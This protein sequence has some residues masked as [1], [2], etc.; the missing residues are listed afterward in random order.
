[1]AGTVLLLVIVAEPPCPEIAC[2]PDVDLATP[3]PVPVADDPPELPSQRWQP[4][5]AAS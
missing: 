3:T 4:T 2:D 5:K 1:L